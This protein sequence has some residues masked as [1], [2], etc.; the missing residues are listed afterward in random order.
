MT[1]AIEKWSVSRKYGRRDADMERLH[2]IFRASDIDKAECFS[3]VEDWWELEL[4]VTDRPFRGR[5][6]ATALVKWGTTTADAEEVCCGVEA[7][8]MGANVYEACGF[9]KLKTS[10]VRV[11]RQKQSLQYDMRRNAVVNL[12]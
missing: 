5:G 9:V 7:S 2:A 12:F 3:D 1:A 10:E 11:P 6:A 8:G 4:L